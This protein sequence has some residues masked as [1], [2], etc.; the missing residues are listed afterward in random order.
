MILAGIPGQ[1]IHSI[2]VKSEESADC[3]LYL[4]SWG[5]IDFT[6]CVLEMFVFGSNL[7]YIVAVFVCETRIAHSFDQ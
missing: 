7:L 4:L 6:L 1:S 5:S 3:I 2:P